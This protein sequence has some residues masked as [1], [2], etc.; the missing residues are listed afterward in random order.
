MKE[1][2]ACRHCFPDT[3]NNCPTDGGEL[4]A[5]I[6]G[7]TVLDGR[8]QLDRRLGQGGMGIVY[9]A[10]HIFLKT[11]YAIKVILP[12]L[13]GN[14][15]M[16][17]TRFRQEAMV[18]ARIGHRNIVNVTDFGVVGGKMPY[19]VMDFIQ[20]KSLHELLS[21]ERRLSSQPALEIMAAIC[22]GVGAAH[23]QGI[24]HRDL[25]PLN[26][27]MKEGVPYS[28]AVKVLDF[29]L[30]KIKS[31]ELLGSFVAAQTTGLMGSPSYMAPELWSEDEPDA[32]ADIY[33]LGVILFQMFA[34]EVPFR[35][36]SL[37]AIMKK[38]L[39][40]SPPRFL[41]VGVNV[42][43]DIEKVVH[44]ALA[45]RRE[46]R[47]SSCEEFIDELRTAVAS[48]EASSA[49][50]SMEVTRDFDAAALTFVPEKGS[51]T[52][53][54][55]SFDQTSWDSQIR[56][57]SQQ[58]LEDEADRLNREFEEAQ[59]RADEARL[60]AE[61]AAQKRAEEEAARRRAEEEAARKLAE[62]EAARQHAVEMARKREQEALERRRV[63]E[64]AAR[65]LAEEE[66]RKRAEEEEARKRVAEEAARLAREIKVAEKRAEE[67]RL[68]AESEARKRSEEEVA[69][70][71]AEEEAQRLAG[72]VAE[73]QRRAQEAR[74]RAEEEARKRAEEEEARRT[75]EE[76]EERLRHEESIR[77]QAEGE[78][79][80]KRGAEDAQ[81]LAREIS[82]AQQRA[83]EARSRAEE[84][85]KKRAE[86]D[87]ARARAE[88]EARKL[89]KQMEELQQRAE[90]S[91]RRSEEEAA[92]RAQLEKQRLRE[93]EIQRQR[94]AQLALEAKAKQAALDEAKAKQAALEKA[95]AIHASAARLEPSKTGGPSGAELE[96]AEET[97]VS[98]T[99]SKSEASMRGARPFETSIPVAP[100]KRS[101]TIPIVIV[102]V[103]VLLAGLIAGG[104]ALYSRKLA[105][106]TPPTTPTPSGSVTPTPTP[107]FKPEMAKIAG[108]SFQMGLND[109]PSESLFDLSQY[110]AR[111]VSVGNFSIDK[112]EVTNSEYAEFVAATKYAAPSYW[113]N[114]KPPAGQDLFPVTYVSVADAKAFA[115]WRSKRDGMKYRLPTEE[116]W[117]YV[118]RNG[119]EGSRYPWGNDWVDGN[120]NVGAVSLEA[121][122]SRQAGAS[123]QG[124]LDLIG[125]AWEWTSTRAAPYPGNNRFEVAPGQVIIRGGAYPDKAR[126]PDAITATRRSWLSPTD[127]QAMIGFRLV[128]E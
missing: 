114:G 43:Y 31:G 115:D 52:A 24:V 20:G 109:A 120:A 72:E 126:G 29:G 92:Q 108:G 2:Q 22:A 61:E 3:F 89:A 28:E 119:Q 56:T 105:A 57:D 33:S 4:I 95:A 87:D 19:L 88:G 25:K 102:V 94:E 122:G 44:R 83:E 53:K 86:A 1:C 12:D 79:A 90:E 78:E 46:D 77:I 18:A 74:I 26:V 27:M 110:P 9:R 69:R 68:I 101:Y 16:L 45:K 80:R 6:A 65:K 73:A 5:S 93:R 70:K 8:Y 97:M 30:A 55:G 91:R 96:L 50:I 54:P 63:E 76:E 81:R 85:A 51:D 66:A 123:R 71:R 125:N 121:V 111:T 32:R 84:E 60:R 112:T 117:E 82:E 103:L 42:P 107:V 124:V 14:D 100:A 17:A 35:G 21:A 23:R 75:A 67:A 38:H 10:R 118:A 13:V 36:P 47:M 104:V 41:D 116:E 49:R 40:D 98:G 7:D 34:G 128:R 113:S 37:P 106:K 39:S 48:A 11:T 127:K 59:R 99:R 58:R 62:E 15:P 64:E